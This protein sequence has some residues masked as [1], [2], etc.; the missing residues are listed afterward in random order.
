MSTSAAAE[1]FHALHAGPDVLVL[2]NCWDAA[3][4]KLLAESGAKAVATSSAAFAWSLGYA[5]GHHLPT[6][7]LIA[8]LKRVARV[9]DLP[10]TADIEGGYSDDPKAV[11]ETV[12]RVIEAGAVGI[13][14]EDGREPHDL[15]RAKIAAATQ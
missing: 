2:P 4:A 8:A 15:H 12:A 14:L 11:S 6:E 5:D 3:S 9:I 7:E 1:A 10:L 13:N